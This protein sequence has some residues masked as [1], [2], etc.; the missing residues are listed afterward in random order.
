MNRFI[1]SEALLGKDGIKKLQSSRIALFGLGGVGGFVMEMLARCAVGSFVLIDHDVIDETNINRQII[2]QEHNIGKYKVDEAKDRITSINREADVTAYKT[3]IKTI[4]DL[5]FLDD[6]RIDHMIDAIDDI[7]GKTAIIRYA[8]CKGIPVISSMGT[9]NRMDPGMFEVCDINA[10]SVCPLAKKVRQR[11]RKEGI[12][13]LKVVYSSERPVSHNYG[14]IGSVAFVPSSAGI[15]L[16]S[17][18]IKDIVFSGGKYDKG[19]D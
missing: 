5:K 11:L 16:A 12:D 13:R 6:M 7:D 4:D 3:R 17:E 1:R 9:G 10:T 19:S 14:F 2:A 8:Y 18:V 15:L